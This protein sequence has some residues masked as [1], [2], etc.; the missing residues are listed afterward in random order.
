MKALTSQHDLEQLISDKVEERLDLEYKG[1]NALERSDAAKKEITKDVS[2]FANSDGGVLIYGI[3]E[4]RDKEKSHLP[5]C[6]DPI[7]RTKFTREWLDQVIG[8]IRPRLDVKIT[9][10][11]LDSDEKHCAYVLEIPKG[12]TA[13][14]ASDRRYYRRFN[15]LAEMMHDH[16][17]RDV[18]SRSSSAILRPK[19]SVR[20]VTTTYQDTSG[21]E[22]QREEAIFDADVENIS[23]CCAQYA[24]LWISLPKEILMRW[25]ENAEGCTR[26]I[27]PDPES[28][29]IRISNRLAVNHSNSIY[30]K[31]KMDYYFAPIFPFQTTALATFYLGVKAFKE[32]SSKNATIKWAI[33]SESSG[34]ARG[35]APLREIR[36]FR[37]TST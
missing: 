9:P 30:Q 13:H 26:V 32:A 3:L 25:P 33:Q 15:F 35:E 27:D 19:F 34:I 5:Q 12:Q 16:E 1:A 17:I 21:R 36:I 31:P 10:I 20:I 4:F 23:S 37:K 6:L 24:M 8:N 11:P 28:V 29:S 2:S 22:S 18:M 7:D 14:Q